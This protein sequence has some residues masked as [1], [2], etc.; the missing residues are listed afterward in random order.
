MR[1]HCR[2]VLGV[3]CGD[4]LPLTLLQ[5]GD[6]MVHPPSSNVRAKVSE[7]PIVVPEKL[8]G[9]A[10]AV[11]QNCPVETKDARL[12]DTVG[13][14]PFDLNRQVIAYLVVADIVAKHNA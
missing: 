5:G 4:V 2:K 13:I 11:R 8:D 3:D 9:M 14:V 1:L 7:E 6:Y 12:I 10:R